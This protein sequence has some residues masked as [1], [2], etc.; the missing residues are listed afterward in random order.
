MERTFRVDFRGVQAHV[1]QVDQL[2]AVGARG[3]ARGDVV[4]F[5]SPSPDRSLVA[6]ELA[7]VQQ[8]RQAG[9]EALAAS[10]T[11]VAA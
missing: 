9:S 11:R 3:A 10:R 1:G 6:H 5:G 8:Q 2:G 7:H 4:A